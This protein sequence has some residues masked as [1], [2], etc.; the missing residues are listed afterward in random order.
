MV[1]A[2]NL[3]IDG[4]D[5][6]KPLGIYIHIPFC[7]KKCNYCDFYS[8]N[9]DSDIYCRYL[10]MIKENLLYWKDK[11]TDR[12][13]DTIYIGGGTPSVLGT[14]LLREL[15]ESVTNTLRVCADAEITIEVNPNSVVNLDLH[16][17]KAAGLNRISMGLQSTSDAELKLLGRSHNYNDTIKAIEHIISSGI[18]NFSLDVMQGI[19]LQTIESLDKTL[20]FCIN[21]GATHISTYMLKIEKNTPFYRNEDKLI[22][23]DE[24]TTADMYEYTCHK[25][26]SNGFRHYEISNFCKDNKISRHN[27]KYWTL[28]DY[29]GIGPS[30]HSLLDKKRFYYPSDL[31]KFC[32]DN[33]IF[34]SEGN[35][36]E[37][38]VMLSLRTDTGLDIERLI[39]NFRISMSESFYKEAQKYEKVGLL[40]LKNNV[41]KLTE[42]G[43]LLSNAIISNLIDRL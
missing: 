42:K 21:S 7:V 43:F 15:L 16:S 2:S 35:T 22:F 39:K 36:A 27:M 26:I 34:E 37:E 30:A 4:D 28:D 8:L 6:M 11:F 33:I 31:N 41:I 13:A 5:S 12:V 20:D 17:L 3:L 29:I 10:K 32:T 9:G 25:L 18:N 1:S 40:I 23:A 24:D 19:P 38:Y 14:R